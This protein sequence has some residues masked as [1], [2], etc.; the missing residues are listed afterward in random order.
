[1]TLVKDW[2]QDELEV[3]I[4][5]VVG[6]V[7]GV[8]IVVVLGGGGETVGAVGIPVAEVIVL[9]GVLVIIGW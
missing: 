4:V 2:Y 9:S 3:G 7:V 6:V 8:R 5:V 1:M